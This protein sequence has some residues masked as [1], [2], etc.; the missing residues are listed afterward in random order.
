MF[1]WGCCLPFLS[2]CIRFRVP[3][4]NRDLG[5][6]THSARCVHPSPP[7]SEKQGWFMPA[8]GYT[9]SSS[10]SSSSAQGT[11]QGRTVPSS[12][13][14]RACPSFPPS[15][16]YK[17]CHCSTNFANGGPQMGNCPQFFFRYFLKSDHSFNWSFL[18]PL[19]YASP[20]V[21]LWGFVARVVP[22]ASLRQPPTVAF[23]YSFF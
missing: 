3:G 19:G 18:E 15:C 16:L 20:C 11:A 21:R 13:F 5:C 10:S 8:S 1:S 17:T 22:L 23:R 12:S 14:W 2:Q 9:L 4:P 7:S 6:W